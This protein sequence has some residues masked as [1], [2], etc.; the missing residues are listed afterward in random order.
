MAAGFFRLHARW[1]DPATMGIAPVRALSPTQIGG[2][3]VLR[4]AELLPLLNEGLRPRAGVGIAPL[5][6]H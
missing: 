1:S 6:L 3:H 5:A 2:W 4:R